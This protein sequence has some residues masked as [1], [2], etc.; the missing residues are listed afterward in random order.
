MTFENHLVDR[1]AALQRRQVSEHRIRQRDGN[2][3]LG[4]DGIGKVAAARREADLRLRYRW[5]IGSWD[6]HVYNSA[7]VGSSPA[8]T[9][10]RECDV[11]AEKIAV[12]FRLV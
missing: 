4:A 8:I 2:G 12:G 1:R 3:V 6:D 10:E 11:C 5:R 7:E 9:I